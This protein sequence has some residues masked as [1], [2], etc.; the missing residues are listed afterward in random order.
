MHWCVHRIWF[1]IVLGN[2]ATSR[3]KLIKYFQI[4]SLQ[5]GSFC[6]L[7]HKLR[8]NIEKKHRSISYHKNIWSLIDVRLTAQVIGFSCALAM[9]VSLTY[10]YPAVILIAFFR[11]RGIL[12]LDR[13]YKNISIV[14][15]NRFCL[16]SRISQR[17]Y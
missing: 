6:V 2:T 16:P 8:K 14:Y 1:H 4:K 13:V 9:Y 7:A 10:L 11:I 17:R 15:L 3:L 5:N 12:R